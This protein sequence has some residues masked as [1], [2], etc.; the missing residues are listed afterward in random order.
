MSSESIV[1]TSADVERLR[2]M[3]ALVPE[4]QEEAIER[5]EEELCRAQ[6][7]DPKGI[8]ANV[9]TMNSRVQIEEPG[10]G[11]VRELTLVYPR[12]ASIEN[13]RVSILAPV[14]SALLGLREG[15]E[16]DWPLPG[17]RTKRIKVVK[18]VYQPEASGDYHL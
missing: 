9:V 3:L 14:G 13:G 17:N 2:R 8:P 5:L 12:E 7:V 18:V 15:Q 11:V 6:I 4:A 10:S 16:I 1:V